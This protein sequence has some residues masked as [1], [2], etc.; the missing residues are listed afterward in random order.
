MMEML[1]LAFAKCPCVPGMCAK[2]K[3]NNFQ[4]AFLSH[5][6]TGTC[7]GKLWHENNNNNDMSHSKENKEITIEVK[8]NDNNGQRRDSII[9]SDKRYTKVLK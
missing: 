7:H 9:H 3:A 1:V 8:Q 6:V 4:S 2:K 5:S